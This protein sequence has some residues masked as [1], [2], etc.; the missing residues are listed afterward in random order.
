MVLVTVKC[1][2]DLALTYENKNVSIEIQP[3]LLNDSFT[4]QASCSIVVCITT[5]RFK[6]R[7]F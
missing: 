6:A 3:S 4:M 1:L 5:L 7:H 2:F